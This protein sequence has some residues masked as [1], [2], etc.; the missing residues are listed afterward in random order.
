MNV[1][2]HVWKLQSDN[3]GH[4]SLQIGNTYVSY[5]PSDAAGK[6]D[7]K[8]GQTHDVS[9]PRSYATDARLERKEC[10]ER[11]ILLG[12]AT[13]QMIEAWAA[14]KSEP[15]RYNMV[16]HNCSTVI[17]ALLELGSGVKPSFVPGVAIDD[18]AAGWPQRLLLRV[19]FM[20]SSIR[21]WT[22][23]AVLRYADE[24]ANRPVPPR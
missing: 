10:D 21:M 11:R 19:R 2:V 6:K 13:G 24:I 23:D 16:A 7:V 17:A 12:L 15:R 14:F 4:A 9:F 18:H 20:S 1:T 8:I 22:P 3:P 5:W